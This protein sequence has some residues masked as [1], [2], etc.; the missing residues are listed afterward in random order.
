MGR[1]VVKFTIVR[2][3][4]ILGTYTSRLIRSH[5]KST[6]L[7]LTDLFKHPRTHKWIPLGYF[8]KTSC[9]QNFK[10]EARRKAKRSGGKRAQLRDDGADVIKA[11][12]GFPRGFDYLAKYHVCRSCLSAWNTE[13]L[14]ELPRIICPQCEER[15]FKAVN[16]MSYAVEYGCWD[17]LCG[18][19][20]HLH[21]KE[22]LRRRHGC[23]CTNCGGYIRLLP[24]PY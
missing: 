20:D 14:L 3:G 4:K 10:L 6:E 9:G 16:L 7:L 8:L 19:C 17:V 22:V 11:S 5:L 23:V 15:N 13:P 12:G 1:V 24:D 2:D 18:L 21:D